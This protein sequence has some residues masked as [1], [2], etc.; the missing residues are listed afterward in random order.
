MRAPTL[1]LELDLHHT[2]LPPIGRL[3]PD[4]AM[5]GFSEVAPY[6]HVSTYESWDQVAR[7]YWRLIE[8]Q[9]GPPGD[10]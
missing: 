3:K 10:S 6:V 5:P 4:A 1:P 9:L 7:W 2:I 8:E